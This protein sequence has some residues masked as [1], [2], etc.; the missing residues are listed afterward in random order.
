MSELS[1]LIDR[2]TFCGPRSLS[3]IML[4]L[5]R[6]VQSALRAGT[7]VPVLGSVAPVA[8]RSFANAGANGRGPRLH[9]DVALVT[10]EIYCQISLTPPYSPNET[11]SKPAS[12]H[13]LFNCRLIVAH[14][15]SVTEICCSQ[16]VRGVS[17]E[18]PL[19]CSPRRAPRW[20]WSI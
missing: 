12:R 10:G 14:A 1:G 16:V 7:G 8:V 9:G 13:A 19:C 5:A 2:R 3:C 18:N 4:R 17:V 15:P 11:M 20:W 6:S